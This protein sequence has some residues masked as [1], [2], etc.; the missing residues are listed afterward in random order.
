[1]ALEF[2]PYQSYLSQPP[3]VRRLLGLFIGFFLLEGLLRL[4]TPLQLAPIIGLVPARVLGSGWVWQLATYPLIQ[5]SP[6]LFLFNLILF[7]SGSAAV[8]SALGPRRFITFLLLCAVAGG[9]LVLALRPEG[10][11]PIGGLAAVTAG[12]VVAWGFLY[13]EEEILFFFLLRMK[14]KHFALAMAAVIVAVNGSVLGIG[15]LVASYVYM[16]WGV[17]RL[18]ARARS[19]FDPSSAEERRPPAGLWRR[20]SRSISGLRKP[21]APVAFHEL[22]QEVDR[23]LEKISRQGLNSLTLEERLLMERYA[24]AKKRI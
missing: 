12:L 16:K 3:V 4:W 17:W 20:V 2:N 7:W 22:G 10:T 5:N 23:I 18:Q 19:R 9:S 14:L 24:R 13:P 21:D 11:Q 8:C 1:M 15:G 6:I